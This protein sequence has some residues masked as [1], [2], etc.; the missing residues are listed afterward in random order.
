MDGKVNPDRWD[1]AVQ[2]AQIFGVRAVCP[3]NDFRERLVASR[4]PSHRL[5]RQD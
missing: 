4:T 5:S 3:F 2:V 1:Q